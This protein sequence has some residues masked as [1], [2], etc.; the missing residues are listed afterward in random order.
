MKRTR[1]TIAV[2]LGVLSLAAGM[3]GGQTVCGSTETIVPIE[4]QQQSCITYAVAT[5]QPIKLSLRPAGALASDIT[6]SSQDVARVDGYVQAAAE[7]SLKETLPSP[8]GQPVV[9]AGGLTATVAFSPDSCWVA[10]GGWDSTARLWDLSAK[11][12]AASP[13][14]LHGHDDGVTAVAIS[15]DNRWVVTGSYDK[16]VRLRDLS[17][18][19]PAANSVALCMHE[20][21]VTA[22]TISLATEIFLG[23]CLAGGLR[24][25]A[26]EAAGGIL[27]KPSRVILRPA[28]IRPV[29]VGIA[30]RSSPGS[31]NRCPGSFSRS[32]SR[33]T[34]SGCGARLS[35]SSGK[36]V[37]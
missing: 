8:G 16:T 17:A 37:C 18:K 20:E 7:R 21:G 27:C 29:M 36:G 15:P 2:V 34:T 28:S 12:P 31:W 23:P 6:R 10:T 32:A 1:Y 5:K 4:K 9:R 26:R 3:L 19:D 35:S 14:V 22:V 11:D 24:V 25:P 30:F 13:L 33:R